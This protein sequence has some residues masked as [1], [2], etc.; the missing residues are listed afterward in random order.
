V[1]P[2]VAH[3]LSQVITILEFVARGNGVSVL[4]ALAL[5]EQQEGLVFRPLSPRTTRRIALACIDEK[6]LSPAAL[7][8]WRMAGKA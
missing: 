5:P 3:E 1:A 2:K 7:A 6:R 4:A 8:F